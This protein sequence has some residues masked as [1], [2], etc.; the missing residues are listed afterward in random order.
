MPVTLLL[1]GSISLTIWLYLAVARGGFW[2]LSEFDDDTANHESPSRWPNV[3]AIVPARNEAATIAQAITSLLQQN[4]PGEF[5]IILVDDHSEDATAQLAHQAAINLNAATRLEIHAAAPLPQS[6]TGK[7]WALNEGVSRVQRRGAALLRPSP[8]TNSPSDPTYYWF[9]DADITHAP[10]TLH[11]LVARAENHQLDLTSLMVQLQAKTLPERALIPAFLFFFLKLYPPSWI[12]NPKAHT[13]GA[14]GGC[15][16]LRSEALHRIGGL[17]AIRHEVIDDCALAQAIKRSG[18]KIWMGLTRASV[19]LRTYSTFPEIRD[20]IARTAFTQLLY[21]PLLLIGTLLG[22]FLTYL[23]PIALLFAS[24]PAP[25]ILAG[26]HLA[27]DVRSLPPHHPLLSPISALGCHS[28][29]SRP[30]LHLP[31]DP[32]RCPLLRRPGRPM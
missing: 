17:A 30:L 8:A 27:A 22:M 21:S 13:A 14:A 9:T 24:K 12:A 25:R 2:R 16:L 11:R 20:M 6:W 4:Y 5:S 28:P 7:L 15:I 3:I 19:S 31:H 23:A 29:S 10:D 26:L 1:I 32:L 18:S